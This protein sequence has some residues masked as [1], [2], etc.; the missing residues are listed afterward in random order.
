MI[1]SNVINVMDSL[2]ARAIKIVSAT[3]RA[4]FSAASTYNLVSELD[5]RCEQRDRGSLSHPSDF[6]SR[7]PIQCRVI[8]SR[9]NMFS[10]YS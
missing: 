7:Q 9:Y 8:T 10:H 5:I 4:E 1:I 6:S 2:L 3:A